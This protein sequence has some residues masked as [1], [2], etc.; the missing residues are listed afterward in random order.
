MKAPSPQIRIAVYG[1]FF[2]AALALIYLQVRRNAKNDASLSVLGE[3]PPFSLTTQAETK[4]TKNDLLGRV[5]IAD[6]IFTTCAGPCPF[7]SAS[8]QNIQAHL[9]P[10]APIALLS[11]SV[12]PQTDTPPVLREY[13]S[14]F[15]ADSSKWTFLTGNQ[16]DIFNLIR[17]GFRLSVESDSD[18]ISHSTKFVLIDKAARIRGYYDSAEDSTVATILHDAAGLAGE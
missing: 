8:M 13:A 3:V 11:F 15:G 6:F 9:S 2:L 18:G 16:S 14:R 17:N 4:F 7:M 10:G 1:L 5:T 12:D